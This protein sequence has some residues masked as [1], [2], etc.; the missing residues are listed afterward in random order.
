MRSKPRAVVRT[1][2][3]YRVAR[4]G[5]DPTRA[6]GRLLPERGKSSPAGVSR[7]SEARL[8]CDIAEQVVH[9]LLRALEGGPHSLGRLG[10]ALL[11]RVMPD[12]LLDAVLPSPDSPTIPTAPSSSSTVLSTSRSGGTSSHRH[13]WIA[14][15]APVV[16]QRAH[17]AR[18]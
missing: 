13:T 8:G 2:M 12:W 5:R 15:A 17:S 18:P 3:E 4:E 7:R 1:V 14:T 11:E 9:E 10:I 6:S 16:V